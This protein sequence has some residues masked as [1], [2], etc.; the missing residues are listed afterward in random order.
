MSSEY[1]WSNPDDRAR[2]EKTKHR[3]SV[4]ESLI[5]VVDIKSFQITWTRGECVHESGVEGLA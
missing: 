1:V 3:V 5:N 4:G 2:N